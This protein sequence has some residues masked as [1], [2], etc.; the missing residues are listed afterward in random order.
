M[1]MK[2]VLPFLIIISFFL[3][4]AACKTPLAPE[5]EGFQTIQI[6]KLNSQESLLSTN[7]KFYNP[8]T[9]NLELKKAEMDVFINDKLVDHYLLDSTIYIA[10]TDTFFI[11]VSLKINFRDIFSN[12]LQSLLNNQIKVRLAGS[13]KLKKGSIGFSVPLRYEE[14]QKLDALLNQ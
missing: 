11:P 7:L 9:F 14:T 12:A 4:I 8:N 5:Y 2:T 1:K 13:A 6:G 10:R 3:C